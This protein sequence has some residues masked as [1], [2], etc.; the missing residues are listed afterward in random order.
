VFPHEDRLDAA[1]AGLR[2]AGA[3]ALVCGPGPDA[4][5][6]SGWSASPSERLALLVVPATGEPALLIPALEAAAVRESTA[7]A[8][9]RTWSDEADP[10]DALVDLVASRGLDASEARLLVDDRLWA[11]HLLALR[12]VAP[13]A[14]LGSASEVLAPLRRRKD[15]AELDALRRAARIAD[16]VLD[17]LRAEPDAVV[18]LTETDLARRIERRLL[19]A[20]GEGIPFE[21]VVAAG[22]NGAHP[23]HAHGDREIRPGEP[24]VL[25]FGTTVAGYPS[26]QTRTLVLGGEPTERLATVHDLVREAGEAAI[27]AVEPGVTAGAV[28]RAARDP[29]AAAGLGD[30]FVHRTGHGVGLEVHEDPYVVA[31]SEVVL[32]PGDVFSV[33][34]GVYLEGEFGVRVEDLVVVTEDGA[35]RLTR[36]DRGYR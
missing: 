36:T 33:E 34:P 32:E 19:D 12:E 17:G 4:R 6:L 8:T 22:P 2:E 28:D 24:V 25:D 7:V 13:A 21:P 30:A 5:Y 18:G 35:E 11:R 20:G 1:R 23:H 27:A 3:T 31:G 26:D 16:G 29:I 14:A 10:T 15:G 9:V